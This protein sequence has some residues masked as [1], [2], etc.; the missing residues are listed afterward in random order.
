MIRRVVPTPALV[1]GGGV[2]MMLAGT[3]LL[4]GG[5][6]HPHAASMAVAA[7]G[8]VATPTPVPTAVVKVV[9]TD[10]ARFAPSRIEVEH[11]STV[12]FVV[13]NAGRLEHEL[14]IGDRAAQAEHERRMRQMAERPPAVAPVAGDPDAVDVPPGETR[15]LVHTFGSRGSLLFG[16]HVTGHY[17]AGMR[18]TIEVI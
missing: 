9:M 3:A 8:D 10:Q 15:T 7:A 17:A 11:G 12:A 6:G 13:T 2:A 16:C 4:L 14:V 5:H 18:G 1:T